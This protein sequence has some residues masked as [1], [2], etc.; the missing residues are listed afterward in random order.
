MNVF[1]KLLLLSDL[2]PNKAK[3]GIPGIG[4]LKGPSLWYGLY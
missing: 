2:K 4:V 1:D 3:C